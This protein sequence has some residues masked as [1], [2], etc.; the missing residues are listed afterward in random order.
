MPVA[1]DPCPEYN[2]DTVQGCI[3]EHVHREGAARAFELGVYAGVHTAHAVRGSSLL[4][5]G[6]LLQALVTGLPYAR[7]RYGDLKAVLKN[8]G[9]QAPEVVTQGPS[10]W[11]S[12]TVDEWA[13]ATAERLM[14]L[15]AHVRRLHHS[16]LRFAQCVA[17]LSDP[18]TAQLQDLLCRL[19]PNREGLARTSSS[20]SLARA[21]GHDGAATEDE[22]EQE[23]G[24]QAQRTRSSATPKTGR[25]GNKYM[26]IINELSFGSSLQDSIK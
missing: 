3:L 24:E 21:P 6:A 8:V 10:R 5:C 23:P 7:V 19:Q 12:W 4:K 17:K 18:E 11:R 15:L 26:Y 20:G 9:L 25:I 1:R 14:V 16:Q 2:L 22:L 13:G